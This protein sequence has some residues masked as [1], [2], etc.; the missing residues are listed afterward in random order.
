VSAHPHVDLER[1]LTFGELTRALRRH[2]LVMVF[3]ALLAGA[4]AYAT[5][6]LITPRFVATTAILSPQ[7]PQN[8][9][10][11]ALASLGSLAGLAG[12]GGVRTPAD[13]YVA[14]MQSV[15]VSDRMIDRYKLMEVYDVPLRMDARK[16]LEKS[17]RMAVGKKDGLI[18]V[19]VEDISPQR[20]AEMANRYIE[21]LRQMTSTLAVTEAQQRRSFF[22]KQLVQTKDRLAQAQA[23]LQGSGFNAGALK[24]EPRA[25]AEAYAKLKAEATAADVRLRTLRQS[26]TD[27]TPEV[28]QQM[29]TLQTL[30]EQLKQAEL[31][32]PTTADADYVGKFRE[33]KYQETLFDL[34]ARQYE[35]ARID[36]SREGTLIQ[37]L[38][39][40][41]PAERKTKPKRGLI[42]VTT[43][44]AVLL[45]WAAFI[46]WRAVR[47]LHARPA[48]QSALV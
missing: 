11:A 36:E 46:V 40:A 48:G 12:V 9:A 38:D 39:P 16:E 45:L 29:T 32:A 15:T 41:L 25:A 19:E 43:A 10:A 22:E 3:G 27:A 5:T 14:L 20:A 2:A 35:M 33:F 18:T 44:L 47:G 28:Q 7:Q 6:Y 26:R 13:Q 42:A 37:V 1:T 31:S 23:A 8:S 4:L 34:F 30:R 24:A 21:E 17:V